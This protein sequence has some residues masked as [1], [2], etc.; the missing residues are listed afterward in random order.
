MWVSHCA[1]RCSHQTLLKLY[2]FHGFPHI[3]GICFILKCK[4]E[5]SQELAHLNVS[6]QFEHGKRS[7]RFPPFH[8]FTQG[9]KFKNFQLSVKSNE[10]ALMQWKFLCTKPSYL[11][12]GRLLYLK[13]FVGSNQ[14]FFDIFPHA[15]PI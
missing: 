4:S 5:F 1:L 9:S 11:K 15:K 3:K 13:T 2:K 7:F 6:L 8:F 12:K 14:A 10:L